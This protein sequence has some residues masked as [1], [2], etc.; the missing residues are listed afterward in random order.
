M[1]HPRARTLGGMEASVGD[2]IAT[3]LEIKK[4]LVPWES[5]EFDNKDPIDDSSMSYF[6]QLTAS[7]ERNE[8]YSWQ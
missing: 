3:P 8:A 5:R 2:A 7:S 1:T 4:K 6:T